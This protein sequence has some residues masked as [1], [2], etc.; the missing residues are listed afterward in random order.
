MIAKLMK[1]FKEETG[2]EVFLLAGGLNG[3]GELA[4]EMYVHCL[5][6]MIY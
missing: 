3:H 5:H 1:T 4:V 2:W 6:E